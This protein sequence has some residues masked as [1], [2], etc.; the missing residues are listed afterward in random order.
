MRT[1]TMKGNITMTKQ[2]RVTV[3][4][5]YEDKTV[6]LKFAK[7]AKPG[8]TIRAYDFDP[9]RTGTPCYIEGIVRDKGELDRG[10]G[11]Y[12]IKL[13]KKVVDGFDVTDE[14]E[15]K[16]WYVPFETDLFEFDTR[17]IK[18]KEAA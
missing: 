2:Q 3:L 12:E 15:N 1:I 10:Y 9:K 16:I 8:D 18:I 5:P 17:V 4:V 11:C 6:N 14:T 7:V 13:T